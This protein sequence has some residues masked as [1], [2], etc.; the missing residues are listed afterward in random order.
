MSVKDDAPT[1]ILGGEPLSEPVYWRG[2][3]W[4]ATAYGVEALDGSYTIEGERL[5]EDDFQPWTV[6]HEGLGWV[7]HMAEKV[8]V[9][10]ADFRNALLE[11]RGHFEIARHRKAMH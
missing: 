1:I 6:G 3:Q 8:W 4:A 10:V 5:W 9:D 2:R 11:A 7:A